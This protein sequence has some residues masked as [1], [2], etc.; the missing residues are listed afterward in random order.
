MS[1]IFPNTRQRRK[2]ASDMEAIKRRQDNRKFIE[3]MQELEWLV[4]RLS[5]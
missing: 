5:S 3:K 2:D 4:A 1:K